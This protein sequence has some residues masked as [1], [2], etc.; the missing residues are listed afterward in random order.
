MVEVDGT[1]EAAQ[2]LVISMPSSAT[3]RPLPLWARTRPSAERILTASR[4]TARLVF[5]LSASSISV[6]SRS[7]TTS[8]DSAMSSRIRSAAISY[9]GR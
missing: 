3:N 2:R 8:G 5:S 7:P 6:G 1:E 4:A 9:P